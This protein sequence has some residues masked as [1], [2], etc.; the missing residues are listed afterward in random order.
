MGEVDQPFV[1]PLDYLDRTKNDASGRGSAI[2]IKRW[3]LKIVLFGAVLAGGEQ[4]LFGEHFGEFQENLYLNVKNILRSPLWRSRLPS[5]L[6]RHSARQKRLFCKPGR[7]VHFQIE[8]IRDVFCTILS[9]E[10]V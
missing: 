6:S 2:C 7:L 5:I 10:K 1:Q 3:A 8:R 4:L 9:T